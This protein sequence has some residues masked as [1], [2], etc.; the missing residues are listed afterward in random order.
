[1]YRFVSFTI[2]MV[3]VL[4][5]LTGGAF[6][7]DYYVAANGGDNNAGTLALPF[8]TIQKAADTMSAGDNC[9][10]RGGSYHEEVDLSGVAGSSGNRITFTNY[11]DEEVI[12]SGT[13]P[14]TSMWTQYSGNIYK[15]TLNEDIWQLFVDPENGD[16]RLKPD[17]PALKLGIV[18]IDLSKIGLRKKL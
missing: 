18:P 6:A 5:L 3:F 1:M 4:A 15:T 2:T 10:I 11:K 16:F 17:S 7:A 12:L 14:I 13:V 9:Y 8:A